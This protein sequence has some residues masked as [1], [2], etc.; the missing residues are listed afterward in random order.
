MVRSVVE[1]RGSTGPFEAALFTPDGEAPPRGRPAFLVCPSFFLPRGALAETLAELLASEGAVALALDYT[2]L[3]GAERGGIRRVNAWDRVDS[4]RSAVGWLAERE[5][6]DP[7]RITL[8]GISGGGST[9]VETMARDPRVAAAVCLWPFGD[10]SRWAKSARN[11]SQWRKMEALVERAWQPGHD[12][13]LLPCYAS[14]PGDPAFCVFEVPEERGR[15]DVQTAQFPTAECRI[16]VRDFESWLH[17]RPEDVIERTFPRPVLVVGEEGNL[18]MP[19]EEAISLARRGRKNVDL[20]TIPRS[21]LASVWDYYDSAD[22]LGAIM[23]HVVSWLNDQE[24]LTP[25]EATA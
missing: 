18:V 20:V 9:V 4:Q 8:V 25:H 7:T 3:V 17:L 1:I 10:G 2:D 13:D 5:D 15:W 11:V 12:E 19:V 22:V 24:L 16:P 23:G 21:T 6:V 14:R